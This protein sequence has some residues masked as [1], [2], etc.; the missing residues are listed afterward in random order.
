MKRFTD[1]ELW[2]KSW[3]MDLTA[4]EKLL[5]QYIKDKCD[6]VGVWNPNKKLAEFYIG[7]NIDWDAFPSKCNGNIEILENGK[8]WVVDYICYQHGDFAF[9]SNN[10]AHKS[11]ITLLARHGLLERVKET[12]PR[13]LKGVSKGTRRVPKA[14]A[15]DKERDK[16]RVK[17]KEKAVFRNV[18]NKARWEEYTDQI[19]AVITHYNVLKSQRLNPQTEIYVK[20]LGILFE[21]EYTVEQCKLVIDFKW[22]E[23]KDNEEMYQY[24]RPD[25]LFAYENFQKYLPFAQEWDNKRKRSKEDHQKHI[26]QTRNRTQMIKNRSKGDEFVDPEFAKQKIGDIRKSLSHKS[27]DDDEVPFEKPP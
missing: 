15:R 26:E 2:D 11:Y 27:E 24:H 1:T 4:A 13:P 10:H 22:E 8:W 21:S 9:D 7:E 3:F 20:L 18:A 12:L 17:D 25:T 23:W 5:F 19:T 16:E 14:R 6:N